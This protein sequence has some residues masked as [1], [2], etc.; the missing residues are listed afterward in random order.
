MIKFESFPEFLAGRVHFLLFS[1]KN[2]LFLLIQI[3]SISP[4]TNPDFF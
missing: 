2:L 3:S 4:P 1:D